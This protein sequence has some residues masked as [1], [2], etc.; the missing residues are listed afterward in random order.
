MVLK[1][2]KGVSPLY[3]FT[4]FTSWRKRFL[5]QNTDP[6]RTIRKKFFSCYIYLSV[7]HETMSVS[8][9]DS[10]FWNIR[11]DSSWTTSLNIDIFALHSVTNIYY[12]CDKTL[13]D[14]EKVSTWRVL[15][16]PIHKGR[17]V[18]LKVQ[19]LF[20]QTSLWQ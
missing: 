15:T 6:W 16:F 17:K 8:I 2:I 5:L 7:G 19:F 4:N 20:L 1:T 12:N 9:Q 14:T 10:N 11:I 18:Y 13:H 3:I